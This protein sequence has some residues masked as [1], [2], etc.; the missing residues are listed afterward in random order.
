MRQL[1]YKNLPLKLFEMTHYSFRREQSGEVAA[2]RRLRTF[3]M[4]DQHTIVA[5]IEMAKDE[6]RKQFIL[7]LKMMNDFE[8]EYEEYF[9]FKKEFYNENK[10]WID[11]MIS[12][13]DKPVML[14]LFDKRY[15]YFVCKF[16]FNVVDQQKKAA[17][18][19]TVQI[20]VENAEF[21]IKYVSKDGKENFPLI[22]HTS[23]SGAVEKVLYAI[24]EK[25]AKIM[26]EGKK[27]N[28]HFG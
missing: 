5:D 20:D 8:L 2:L 11:K 24:L 3:S 6:F 9:G 18:L 27:L 23:L 21:D 15:A 13:I 1:I 22:L 17:A 4:P 25:S 7:C 19:S 26:R 16:E 28:S 14:E 12:E 10:S